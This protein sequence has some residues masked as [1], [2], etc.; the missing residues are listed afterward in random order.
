MIIRLYQA[1]FALGVDNVLLIRILAVERS[2]GW[3]A[4]VVL[5]GDVAAADRDADPMGVWFLRTEASEHL[6][7]CGSLV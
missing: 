5:S 3:G 1:H 4:N 7:V 2:V 6:D